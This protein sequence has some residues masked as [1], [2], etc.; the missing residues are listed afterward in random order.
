MSAD[1]SQS[2]NK[3]GKNPDKENK[4]SHK[5]EAERSVEEST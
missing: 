5:Q 1:D 3:T 4:S 2:L